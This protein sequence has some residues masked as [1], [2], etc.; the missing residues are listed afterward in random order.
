MKG[1]T[2]WFSLGNSLSGSNLHAPA[3]DSSMFNAA[4]DHIFHDEPEQDDGEEAGENVRD[5]ELS[6]LFEDVPAEAAR[7]GADAEDQFGGDQGTPRKCPSD[8]QSGED[9]GECAGNQDA[10]D[11]SDSR[12]AV[13]LSDH[14]KGWANGSETGVGI[15]SDGPQNGVD[16]NEDDASIAQAEPNERQR[17]KGDGRQ[18]IEHRGEGL[19]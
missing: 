11:I 1:R 5:E 10:R 15:E 8:F 12:Q 4:E 9:A 16:Q 18:R 7:S 14:P 19:K 2:G 17:K 13:V 3:A 6:F